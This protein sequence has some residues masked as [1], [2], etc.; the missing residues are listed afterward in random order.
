MHFAEHHTSATSCDDDVRSRV[1]D[2]N[3]GP[4]SRWAEYTQSV[5][6]SQVTQRQCPVGRVLTGN[7]QASHSMGLGAASTE[8]EK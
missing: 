3:P 8:Q 5:E 7:P 1:S 4:V 6:C 2:Q